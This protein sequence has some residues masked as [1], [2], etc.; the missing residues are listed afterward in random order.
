V[1]QRRRAVHDR[2]QLPERVRENIIFGGSD[3][4]IAGL[5]P[6]DITVRGNLVTK[7]LA[8]KAIRFQVKNLFELKNARRVVVDGNVF[9]Y[10][11][12]S[13]QEGS[14][15][16]ITVRNQSGKLPLVHGRGRHVQPQ[17]RAPHGE[18]R[19]HPRATMTQ[20]PARRA[21]ARRGSSSAT[22][23]STTSARTSGT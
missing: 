19:E 23:C 8:W 5:V 11:W 3:P 12:T 17:H 15:I 1:L 6:S 7:D 14:G 22:T 13:G 20:R 4:E 18:R 10:S 21:A 2:R 16:V 9:E